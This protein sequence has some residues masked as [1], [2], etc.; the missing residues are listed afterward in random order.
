[1]A[2]SA[3]LAVDL[4]TS[5][6]KVV[7]FDTSGKLLARRRGETPTNLLGGG[8]AEHDV[9]A[10]WTVVTGL[11]SAVV[12]DLPGHRVEAVGVASVGEA[13]VPLD[14]A[15][16][17][18]RHAF[19]WFDSRGGSEASWWAREAGPAA[20]GRITGQAIDPQCGVNRLMWMREHE[21]HAFGRVRHWL[22]L[23]DLVIHGL[24]GAYA[25]D[26]T[27]AS[28]TMV[29]DQRRLDWSDDLL[30]LAGLDRSLFPEVHPS[31]TCVGTVSNG[32]VVSTGLPSGTPVVTGGHDRLCA[33]FAA[34]GTEQLPVDSTGSAEALVLP[35]HEYAEPNPTESGFVACYADVVP[36]QFVLSAR[37]GYAGALVDWYRREVQV[38]GAHADHRSVDTEVE[39]PLSFSGLL[40]YPSFG[41]VLGPT[42]DPATACGAIVGLTLGHR[43]SHII[44]ALIEGVGYSL[45]TNLEWIERLAGRAIPKIR[46]EG[47]LT[48]SR[49]W[50]QLKADVTGRRV[51]GL[52]LEEATALGAALLA[53]VGAG[54]YPDHDT[55][56]AVVA[57]E[58]E[59]W[60]PSLELAATYSEVF[61][62]GFR[63]LP[64]L[65]GDVAPAL[66][67]AARSQAGPDIGA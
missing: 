1:M 16:R 8:R 5:A 25:T 45:R 4:G 48:E 49:V 63:R 26:F 57:R 52:R 64:R 46:V 44:Q 67:R 41:R 54:V 28:R 24:C 9:D 66:E 15:G 7:A 29:F 23:A 35:I 59:T 36:G 56:A 42:W 60:V 13:G 43:R 55:A 51:E 62:H 34:R 65:I 53:G 11:I 2:P 18:V 58:L 61:E 21:P 37:V 19:A 33:A 30:G 12:A 20:V 17:P 14:A 40:C 3:L 6:V 32:A 31:G 27:L 10:L 50:M 39:W 47:A 38:G 22:S